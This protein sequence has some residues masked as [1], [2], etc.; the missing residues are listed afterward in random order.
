MRVRPADAD[1]AY[2]F[3]GA[4]AA[5]ATNVFLV[6][7]DG[8]AVKLASLPDP[9]ADVAGDGATTYIAARGRVLKLVAGKPPEVLLASQD[10]IVSIALSPQGLFYASAARVG[11]LA[12]DGTAYD[13]LSQGGLLR[14]RGDALYVLTADGAHLARFRPIARFDEALGPSALKFSYESPSGGPYVRKA[15]GVVPDPKGLAKALAE[16]QPP[17]GARGGYGLIG[18]DGLLGK[19]PGYGLRRLALVARQYVKFDSIFVVQPPGFED[20]GVR[21]GRFTDAFQL[22]DTT[23]GW[24]FFDLRAYFEDDLKKLGY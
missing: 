11:Y 18:D 3:G 4:D 21:S 5:V 1:T 15:S 22:N 9:I 6:T 2:L 17:Q 16:L 10:P 23:L 8:R 13:F 12:S 7:R 20:I 19:E 14:V 24:M